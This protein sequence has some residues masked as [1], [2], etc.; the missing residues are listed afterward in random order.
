ML[1]WVSGT[2]VL[3]ATAALSYCCNSN[4]L[5]STE[6]G[7]YD[8]PGG[9]L[10]K[11]K[12]GFSPI[13]NLRGIQKTPA[14]HQPSYAGWGSWPPPSINSTRREWRRERLLSK[15]LDSIPTYLMAPHRGSCLGQTF[16]GLLQAWLPIWSIRK[17]LSQAS[18]LSTRDM[19]EF[20][21]PKEQG[22]ETFLLNRVQRGTK[23]EL[24][25]KKPD[26]TG[27]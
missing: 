9:N 12:S 11:S 25:G 16:C 15:T 14:S 22:K 2:T 21:P 27:L 18:A 13:P 24:F 6:M 8:F 20:E 4:S 19:D 10:L 23:M 1:L 26:V 17:A 7:S 5:G 3:E